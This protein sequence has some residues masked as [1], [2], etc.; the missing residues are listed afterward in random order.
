MRYIY[1]LI[2]LSFQFCESFAQT[3]TLWKEL[4]AM[5]NPRTISIENNHQSKNIFLYGNGYVSCLDYSFQEKYTEKAKKTFF[6]KRRFYQ[7]KLLFVDYKYDGSKSKFGLYI[8]KVAN[9]FGVL[10]TSIVILEYGIYDERKKVDKKTS[11]IR[12]EYLSSPDFKTGIA[13][14]E[15]NYKGNIKEGFTY[16]C[17]DEKGSLGEIEKVEFEYLD[18]YTKLG[19]FYYDGLNVFVI[20]KHYKDIHNGKNWPYEYR[21]LRYNLKDK[22]ST[23]I[24]LNL[25]GDFCR[26]LD[27][28]IF[29][30]NLFL[31]AANGSINEKKYNYSNIKV[32]KINL[33]L[34]V[35]DSILINQN[36]LEELS[37]NG[38]LQN[39]GI[40]KFNIQ[41]VV[42]P[43]S[44]GGFPSYHLAYHYTFKKV[45]GIT[46]LPT[47][48]FGVGIGPKVELLNGSTSNL[49]INNSGEV[50]SFN[51]TLISGDISLIHY[52]VSAS[53]TSFT[54]EKNIHNK[55]KKVS[56][57]EEIQFKSDR[58]STFHYTGIV[59]QYNKKINIPRT[60]GV[61]VPVIKGN[62]LYLMKYQE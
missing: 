47:P 24:V 52:G 31:L 23:S 9:E 15:N 55:K 33:D 54:F 1:I 51:D 26:V 6:S 19:K 37:I 28:N 59:Y 4:S 58:Q 48:T 34:M 41:H 16:R 42:P 7:D 8:N 3:D 11:H 27:L 50:Y 39:K 18:A 61:A 53:D 56:G 5:K 20:V 22:S 43:S 14:Y 38:K 10:D 46:L 62:K 57:Y 35:L 2:V 17:F 40:F 32:L 36:K 30:D 45:T 60:R 25:K 44:N 29:N 13:I 49:F 12:M 21:L